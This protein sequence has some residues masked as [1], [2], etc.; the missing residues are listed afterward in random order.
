MALVKELVNEIDG[1]IFD[2]GGVLVHHQTDEDHT[3]MAKIAG[4]PQESFSERYWAERDAYDEGLI[5]NIDYWTSVLSSAGATVTEKKI[6]DLTEHDTVSWMRYDQPMWDWVDELKRAGK[7]VAMLSNM[8]QEIGEALKTRSDKLDRFHHVTLSYQ[9]QSTKPE[10][11]IY[12]ECLAGIGTGAARTLFLDDRVQNVQG[13]ELLGI[14]ALQFTSRD[15]I[16]GRL[17]G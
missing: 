2:Y 8:P 11:A 10:P 1:V 16:L 13:G 9:I 4:A 7:R 12:E 6:D 5:S 14:R 3:R 15:E 17:R